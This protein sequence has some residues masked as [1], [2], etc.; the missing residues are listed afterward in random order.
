MGGP[1]YDLLMNPLGAV[2]QT[3]EK[4]VASSQPSGLDPTAVYRGKDWGIVDVLNQFL[5]S[6]GGLAQVPILDASSLKWI[7]PNTLVRFRGMVQDMLGNEFYIGAFK[8]GCTWRTNKFLDF[9]PFS[10]PP[11]SETTLWERHLFHCVPVPGQNSWAIESTPY[12]LKINIS[13]EMTCQH[14]E[15]RR[16]DD[17]PD[18]ISDFDCCDEGSSSSNKK[19]KDCGSASHHKIAEITNGSS[20]PTNYF[21]CLVKVYDMPESQFKLNEVVEFIGIYTFDPELTTSN[22]SDSV[23]DDI[24][25]FDFMDDVATHLPPSKVPRIHC[26]VSQKLS[27]QDLISNSPACET[28]PNVIRGIRDSLVSYLSCT[29][30]NDVI[31]AQC[32]LLH[33]LSKLRV[34]SDVA[35]VGR[36]SLNLTGFTQESASIFG[37]QLNNAIKT[38]LPYSHTIPLTIE[39]LNTAMLQPKKDNESGRFLRLLMGALQLASGTHLTLDETVMQSGTLNS[40]GVENVLLLKHLMEHQIVEY[41]FQFYKL[42]MATEVQCLII[43]EAKSNILP[44]DLVVPMCPSAVAPVSAS[45][46]QL[47]AWRWYLTTVRSLPHSTD[48]SICEMLQNEMVEAMRKDRS[49]GCSDLSRWMTMAQL[50]AASFGEKSLS[51]EHWQMVKEIERLRK[52]RL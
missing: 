5:F 42:E 1:Q 11:V 37:K 8:D 26:L 22:R 47:H 43:S 35:S 2:R 21:S 24:S 13:N 9:S 12:P 6:Q 27:T 18:G 40:K 33:L 39:Y 25:M 44:A 30:G 28:L 36:L 29:L 38:L 20:F 17:D 10:V 4:A 3:F 49:L 31:A 41:D 52:E 45:E 46:E 34:K 7:K 48:T 32:L 23:D 50:M 15:K 51:V 14:G 16:R 19:Q